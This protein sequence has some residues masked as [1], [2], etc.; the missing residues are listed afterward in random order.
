MKL[1]HSPT[2]PYVRKVMVLIAETGLSGIEMVEVSGTPIAPDAGVVERNPLGK[3]PALERDDGPTLYD[4]RVICQFLNARAGA[5]LYPAAP[6]LWDTLTV[7]A[8]ADG[9]LDAALLMVYESRIRPEDKRYAPWVEGQWTKIAR[10]LDVLETR[11]IDHLNAQLDMGQIATACALGY[12][13]FRHASRNWRKGHARLAE[14]EAGFSE[15]ASLR[16]TVPPG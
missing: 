7:E 16:A 3:I 1:Y 13:D 10:A 11:W 6:R 14:W 9:M 5:E 2:S 15:R 12:L 8:T 4:S